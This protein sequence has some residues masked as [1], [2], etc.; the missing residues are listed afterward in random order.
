MC[1]FKL[2]MKKILYLLMFAFAVISCSLDDN[3]VAEHLFLPVESVIMPDQFLENQIATIQIKYRR[4]TD[5]HI[6]NGFYYDAVANTRT[7]AIRAVK[8][9]QGNC[10][11][12]TENVF[13]VPLDFKPAVAGDYLFKFWAGTDDNGIDQYLEYTIIVD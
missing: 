9:S 3:P 10:M 12:D 6:F 11:D 1:K 5:C 2:R 7:V 13:E 4:P 8:L